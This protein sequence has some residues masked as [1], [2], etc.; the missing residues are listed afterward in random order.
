MNTYVFIY[1]F[2]CA[3]FFTQKKHRRL[4]LY[5]YTGKKKKEKM[6]NTGLEKKNFIYI[7]SIL[8]LYHT[9]KEF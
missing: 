1:F 6:N 7:Y 2:F 4:N 9:S 5:T 8:F 3:V